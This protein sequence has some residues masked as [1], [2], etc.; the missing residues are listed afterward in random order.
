MEQNKFLRP[1]VTGLV[2]D[3]D[4]GQFVGGLFMIRV[5][6]Y[7]HEKCLLLYLHG[8]EKLE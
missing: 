8:H 2:L 6:W 1:V 5:T 7:I 4:P 3:K